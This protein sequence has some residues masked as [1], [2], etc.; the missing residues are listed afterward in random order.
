MS[1]LHSLTDFPLI[2]CGCFI[3]PSDS[4]SSC[5]KDAPWEEDYIRHEITHQGTTFLLLLS[6]RPTFSPYTYHAPIKYVITDL[7]FNHNIFHSFCQLPNVI[8]N[9]FYLQTQ[10]TQTSKAI[11]YSFGFPRNLFLS[12]SERINAFVQNR[13]F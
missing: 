8:R 7:S 3:A 11:N 6:P 5:S 13:N 1:C 10:R 4:V 9:I 2:T 12:L